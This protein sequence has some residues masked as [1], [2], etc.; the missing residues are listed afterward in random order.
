MIKTN[1]LLRKPS[2]RVDAT[3]LVR[4]IDTKYKN[5]NAKADADYSVKIPRTLLTPIGIYPVYGT[6]TQLSKFLVAGQ[7]CIIF[8]LMCFLLVPHLIW[9]WFDAQ[10][11]K[12]LMK[13]IAAQ[14]FNSLALLKFWTLI[15]NKKA[16]RNCLVELEDTWLNVKC[17]EDRLVMMKNAKIGRIFT[18]AYLSLSYGGALPYHIAL[19]LT[20]ER[21][22]KDDNTT[23]IPLPYPCDYVFF[24]PE[25]SP[26][27]EILFFTHIF[28]STIILS[29]NTGIYS[30]IA[31]YATFNSGLF[32]VVCRHLD[33]FLDNGI[34]EE[35]TQRLANIIQKHIRAIESGS[36][37][38]QL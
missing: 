8:G 28:I 18:I 11:L 30:L 27:Y 12:K 19:P 25:D 33:T 17:E 1:N 9:T 23:L 22:I 15:I 34:N 6:D 29:T 36:F 31:T 20:A 16:L 14:V 2:N 21:I 13:I 4:E 37:F 10:D 35:L 32:E 26:G 24:V 3:E 38:F 5:I 7:I